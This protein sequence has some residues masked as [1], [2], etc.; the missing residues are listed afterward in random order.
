MEKCNYCLQRISRAR[1]T[2]E[3]EGRTIQEGEM[4]TACQAAC[5]TQ[6]IHFGDL[7]RKDS[8]V[9]K[10]REAP[11]HYTLLEE[12]NTRPRTTYLKRVFNSDETG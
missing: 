8:D 5:P 1:K 12:L 7:N 10:L 2:A 4:V 3:K 6:A 11:Q 9:S